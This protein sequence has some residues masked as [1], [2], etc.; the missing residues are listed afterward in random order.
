MNS[1]LKSNL[2]SIHHWLRLA[3][4][5]LFAALLQVAV[6]VMWILVVLQFLMS[7]F[8]GS[9]HPTLRRFGHSLSVFIYQ[10]WQFLSYNSEEKPFPFQEW[11]DSR[12]DTI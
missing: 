8:T 12:D 7:L 1:Q 2:T 6:A 9:D 4:M 10:S 11:P 5:V 3:Y